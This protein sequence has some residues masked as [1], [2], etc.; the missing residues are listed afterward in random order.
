[1]YIQNLQCANR[2]CPQIHGVDA[3]QLARQASRWACPACGVITD[4]AEQQ[5]TQP[6]TS[7]DSKQF[8]T[9]VGIGATVVGLIMAAQIA[10]R[11]LQ[12][13]AI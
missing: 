5:I 8:W 3:F 9:V 6:N 10:D 4:Y 11:A 13:M 7:P 1:M 12:R 2:C